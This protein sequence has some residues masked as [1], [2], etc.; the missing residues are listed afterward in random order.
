MRHLPTSLILAALLPCV[1]LYAQGP[2]PT[3][4]EDFHAPGTQPNVLLSPIYASIN[5]TGCHSGYD[6]DQEPYERW[7]A[8]M[9]AQA[10]RDP[11]FHAAFAI[12]NQDANGAGEY[13]LR[14]HA[15]GAWLDGRSTPPDGSALNNG[16]GDYDGVTCHLCHRMVDPFPAPEN[17]DIDDRVLLY[18][19]ELPVTPNNAQ[20]VIDPQDVRRGP[21]DLGPNFFFHDWRQSPYHQDSLLC[22]TCHDLSNPTLSKQ[23]DGSY[24]LNPVNQ[25]APS[26]NKFDL[27][28]VER[29]FSEWTASQYARLP[30]DTRD[31]V[32]PAGRFGGNKTAV[33]TCQDCHMP[34]TTGQGCAP[35]F[36]SPVRNDLPLHNFTG[37]NNWVLLAVRALWPDSETGLTDSS[38]TK[39]LQRTAEMHD[40]ASDM[41][42]SVDGNQLRVRIVNQTA[43]KL[44]TGYSEGRRAWINVRF[45]DALDNV[46]GESGAYDA[47][48]ATLSTAGTKIYHG[49]LG[50]D[51]QQ[52][53]ATGRPVG[54]TMH[55]VLGNTWLLDNRIPPRGF[56]NAGFAAVQAAPVA[57]TYAEEQ[58]WDETVYTIPA[59]AV[60]ATASMYHQTTTKEYIEFLR[61]T[62]TTNNAG[63]TAY[64]QWLLHGK[65]APSLM[66]SAS[67][68][69]AGQQ[70]LPPIEYGVAKV[71]SLGITPRLGASGAASA[72]VAG[73]TLQLSGGIPG[74]QAIFRASGSS[75]SVPFNGGTLYL[76][77]GALTVGRVQIDGAG[78]GSYTIP[79][80]G[81]GGQ[82]RN[83]QAFFRDAGSSFGYGMTNGL[84]VRF[85]N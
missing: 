12:A 60:R 52:A 13:C 29:T 47:A 79:T 24:Q 7:S 9:K 56:T 64:S 50:I 46:V 10:G 18:T 54:P 1:P 8:S 15:P 49:E 36:G 48:T 81:L 73:F 5:C 14:C 51:A 59:G 67:V 22:A 17:P 71:N 16:L 77:A 83:Y 4:L 58:Y 69:F 74:S 35:V 26:Q 6:P 43:H 76:G 41:H 78:A 20:F 65:S 44:P 40:R 62:N 63:Q 19:P 72:S 2:L 57:A 30:V 70:A 84:H 31:S 28:P 66:D 33:Q 80:A 27:F 3:T 23:V 55:F 82:A 25:R 37:S 61:D 34:D 75:A 38:V 42:L 45:Y 85:V 68:Q 32:H 39:A 21:F 53:A 11:I